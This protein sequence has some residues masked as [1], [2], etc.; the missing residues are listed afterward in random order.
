MMMNKILIGFCL[1]LYSVVGFS[2]EEKMYVAVVDFEVS[3]GV[4]LEGKGLAQTFIHPLS[5]TQQFKLMERILIRKVLD[6]QVLSSSEH[7]SDKARANKVGDLYGVQAIVTGTVVK[8][9]NMVTVT[10]QLLD[11]TTGEILKSGQIVSPE[12]E[13]GLLPSV[14]LPD[15]ARQLAGAPEAAPIVAGAVSLPLNVTVVPASAQIKVLNIAPKYQP[16]MLLT[17][18]RY[19]IE[20]SAP[21]YQMKQNWVALTAASTTFD[22]QL[23]ANTSETAETDDVAADDIADDNAVIVPSIGAG[24]KEFEK[25]LTFFQRKRLDKAAYWL[26]QSA[27]LGNPKA[28]RKIA[29]L[30]K[31]SRYRYLL[32]RHERASR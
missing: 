7:V 16:G 13:L 25:A 17:P 28:I 18:G 26:V 14:G 19:H 23:V 12:A 2:A 24:E 31:K 32:K 6:E 21:G 30:K 3:G 20:V 10:A 9:G 4:A 11:A 5:S 27:R 22:F 29:Q 8:F 1:C 15:L